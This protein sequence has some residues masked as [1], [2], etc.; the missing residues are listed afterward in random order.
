MGHSLAAVAHLLKMPI[1]FILN[2]FAIW[3][4]IRARA[5]GACPENSL[6]HTAAANCGM[7]LLSLDAFFHSVYAANTAVW[8]VV[9]WL[10]SVIVPESDTTPSADFA[11]NGISSLSLT[12]DI[13]R[14]FLEGGAVVGDAS[15]II[16]LFD[17]ERVVEIFDT[18]AQDVL[19]G[20]RR[21][22][23]VKGGGWKKK[24][25]EA[26]LGSVTSQIKF[27]AKGV[28][29]LTKLAFAVASMSVFAGADLGVLLSSQDPRTQLAGAAATAPPIAWAHFT[30]ETG[31]P[32]V[33]DVLA[34]FQRKSPSMA[35]FW[36]HIHNALDRF[37]IIIDER[38]HR[39]CG[40][41]RYMLG[42]SSYL[43]RGFY[44]NCMA[45]VAFPR[46][47]LSL[48]S[49]L[50][51]DMALYRCLCVHPVGEDYV[52][53]VTSQ[54]THYIPPSRRAMWQGVC[55]FFFCILNF[56]I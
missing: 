8:D 47:M 29:A 11:S 54:C 34:S 2:P 4:L 51:A 24:G 20:R 5:D 48:G 56:F 50:F 6:M 3:E 14:S 46:A 25:G 15:R 21:L 52:A 26:I 13:L 22:L 31:I 36:L 17:I 42:Y 44:Y 35:P 41:M 55:R 40:G 53:Y 1:N 19:D 49:I 12:S 10:I 32:I 30:Y 16:T 39:A 43:A 18:G 33:L 27:G 38:L 45:T 9:V 7:Q 37:D 23:M 28:L